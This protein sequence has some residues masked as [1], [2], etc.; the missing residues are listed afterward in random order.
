MATG[1]QQQ[2]QQTEQAGENQANQQ[3]SENRQ[4]VFES[5]RP[6][7]KQEPDSG[8][9]A[10]EL[11]YRGAANVG[12]GKL[13][14]GLGYFSIALGL[15]ELLM[16]AQ[17]G[18]LIGVSRR[19]R[20]FLPLLGL[21]EIAHG[22]SILSQE[23][24]TEA[25]WARVGGDAV[26]L[27]YLGAAFMG[28]ENNKNRLTGATL[29]VLGVTVLDVL[30]AQQLSSQDWGAAKNPTAPTTVGQPSARHS[31]EQTGNAS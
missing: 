2:N 12:T 26:D 27:A 11:K 23:K 1:T 8:E 10:T 19:Y 14:K 29:A 13:A 15:S 31:S 4:T 20:S 7:Y 21:R 24:P 30:C 22:I 5:E 16:P 9:Y 18:E 3:S 6:R 25:V 17:V 28:R